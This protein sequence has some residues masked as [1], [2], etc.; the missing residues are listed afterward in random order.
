MTDIHAKVVVCR[1]P[2]SC[3]LEGTKR[4]KKA[5]H[6]VEYLV[7]GILFFVRIFDIRF[8]HL[9]I[10]NKSSKHVHFLLKELA[11][12]DLR[13]FLVTLLKKKSHNG[14]RGK[15]LRRR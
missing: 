12:Y 13:V 15:K 2:A 4:R 10:R 5:P 11:F 8:I 7:Q 6:S 14:S 1:T 3:G 9:F